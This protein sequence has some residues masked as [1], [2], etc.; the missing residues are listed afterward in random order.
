MDENV[1]SP[2]AQ[3]A[4]GGNQQQ[5]QLFQM[6]MDNAQKKQGYLQQQQEAYNA[7]LDKY[8]QMVQQSQQPGANEAQMWGNMA[9]AAARVAPTWGNTGAMIAGIGGAYGDQQAQE[10]QQ[11]LRSQGDLTKLRQNE[12]RALEAKDQQAQMMKALQPKG[13]GGFIQFKDDAGNTYIMDKSTGEKQIIPATKSK[14]WEEALKLGMRRAI[15]EDSPDK[16][17][18]AIDYANRIL[19]SS[20]G[21]KTTADTLQPQTVKVGESANQKGA[22]PKAPAPVSPGMQVPAGTQAAR[23]ADRL[24]ILRQEAAANP[25]DKGLQNEL[26]RQEK[27]SQLSPED[28]VTANRLLARIN[29][30][31]QAAPN[32]LARLDAIVAKY[33]K[34]GGS[35]AEAAGRKKE[36]E[37]KAQAESSAEIEKQKMLGKAEGEKIATAGEDKAKLAGTINSMDDYLKQIDSLKSHPGLEKATGIEGYIPGRG[38]VATLAG[39][40]SGDFVTKLEQAKSGS[41]M[42]TLKSIKE[43]SKTGASGFGSLTEKEADRIISALMAIDINKQGPEHVKAELNRVSDRISTLKDLAKSSYE[44]KHGGIKKESPS[45]SD[46]DKEARYQAWKKSRGL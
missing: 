10:M 41:L 19:Q 26:A 5:G 21:S 20:P 22:I 23:D 33:P 46:S 44:S 37:L 17:S 8:A 14:Q 31:P 38:R 6:M 32:D 18:A 30:N 28:Q 39:S 1:I 45:S 2:L 25:E 16:D 36:A 7:D 11:N 9:Q 42:E 40:D 43:M 13:G 35:I 4:S 29:A 27:V 15:A 3:T 34:T 12:V 24:A